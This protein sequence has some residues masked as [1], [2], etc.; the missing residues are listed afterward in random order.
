MVLILV[1]S[2]FRD[3]KRM[4]PELVD[5]TFKLKHAVFV[6]TETLTSILQIYYTFMTPYMPMNFKMFML[7]G[8]PLNQFWVMLVEVHQLNID[9]G[10]KQMNRPLKVKSWF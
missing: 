5:R 10:Y 4:G 9:K 7:L 6:F 3:M 1:F 2:F 8:F